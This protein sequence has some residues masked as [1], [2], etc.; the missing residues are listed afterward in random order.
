[1]NDKIDIEGIF[2]DIM[3]VLNKHSIPANTISLEISL[4]PQEFENFSASHDPRPFTTGVFHKSM[5][6]ND[7]VPATLRIK[8][9]L[10]F[11]DIATRLE[12]NILPM[13]QT[14][15]K[16]LEHEFERMQINVNA[17]RSDN[18]RVYRINTLILFI[19]NV[20]RKNPQNQVVI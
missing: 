17:V 9:R 18:H 6:I 14:W 13:L 5:K 15:A 7:S 1:M 19:S 16:E 11:D 12:R 4:L 10:P 20:D 3:Q 8:R 2:K